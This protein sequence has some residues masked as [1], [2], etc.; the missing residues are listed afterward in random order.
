MPGAQPSDRVGLGLVDQ[1]HLWPQLV[2]EVIPGGDDFLGYS[3]DAVGAAADGELCVVRHAGA[4]GAD[5]AGVG[6]AR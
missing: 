3:A 1:A 2:D 6:S 5:R 4:V